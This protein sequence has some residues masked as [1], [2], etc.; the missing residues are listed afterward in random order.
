MQNSKPWL[1]TGIKISCNNKRK[2]Y[3][4]NGE[5]TD[6]NLKMYC[7]NYCKILSKVITSAKKMYYNN[8]LVN[9]TNKPET[10][11]NIIKTIAN[12][13]KNH[14]NISLMEIDGKT[15]THHQIIAE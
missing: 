9:S 12:N 4:L 7:K 2:L 13:K 15:S 1:T 14:N 6:H 3:L 8:K 11:R 5:S 10:T